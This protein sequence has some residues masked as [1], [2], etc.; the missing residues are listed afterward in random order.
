MGMIL[1]H[2]G[3]RHLDESGF[4]AQFCDRTYA[5]ISHAR[6]QSADELVQEA[7]QLSFVSD[8]P[9]DS[10]GDQFREPPRVFIG[11]RLPVSLAA[12]LHHRAERTH[13]TILLEA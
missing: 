5:A 4:R 11:D 2:R 12:S 6:S 1:P 13:A 8:P 9:F 7:V 3:R 10:F